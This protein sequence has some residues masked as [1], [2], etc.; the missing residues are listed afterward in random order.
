MG[1][2]DEQVRQKKQHDEEVFGDA[3]IKMARAA[4]GGKIKAALNGGGERSKD[5]MGEILKF[6]HVKNRE[7][8]DNIKDND[9][10]L[11]Y[12]MRP[13]GI[14]RR[15]VRLL[16]GWHKDA[17][18]AMLGMKKDGGMVA[19]IPAGFFGYR[20]YDADSGAYVRIGKKNEGLFE[21]EAIAFYKPLPMKK[22]GLRDL[23]RY[24]IDTL[25][26]ADILFAALTAFAAALFGLAAPRLSSL[27]FSDVIGSG[28]AR[29]LAAA[30]IFMACAGIG[31][32]LMAGAKTL[33]HARIGTKTGFAVESAVMMRILSLPVDFFKRYSS[34]ELSCRARHISSLSR[35]LVS[36]LLSVGLAA[37]F[38]LI[39]VIQIFT[40]APVLAAPAIAV[41]AAEL[42]ILAISAWI[43]RKVSGRRMKLEAR[44]GGM[45]YAMISGIQKIKLSGAEK[46]AFARWGDLY[47]QCVRLAYHPPFFLK[48]NSVMTLAVSL[49]GTFAIYDAA[50]SLRVPATDYYA[51]HVAYG[52]VSAAFF[53]LS[54][55]ALEAAKTGPALEM[56]RP[57]LETEPE[58]A[59]EKQVVSRISGGIELNNV[60]FRYGEHM[61]PVLDDLTLKI[62]PGQYVAIVGAT[63]CGKSTL[64][65]LML[66]FEK[67]Q[68]GAVFYDGRD[69]STLD[70]K[71]LRQKIGVVLQ[72]GKLFS[73]D[74]YSNITLLAPQLGMEGAW[75]AAELA[76]AA[77]DIKDMPMGMFTM[78]SEGS[79]GISGGQR[80]RILIA[81]AIAH[82]PRILMFDEATSALD[83]LTQK[84]V[85]N[86]LDGMKCTRIVI[87]HRLSTIRQCDRI[88][89]LD[90]GKI[91]EDGTYEELVLRDGFFAGLVARQQVDGKRAVSQRGGCAS[92]AVFRG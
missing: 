4:S 21:S 15:T 45:G 40:Y 89:V 86:A 57:I 29:A 20:Y 14:M 67:P 32:R 73:G 39:Y 54:A 70:L 74:I 42:F 79:G 56:A 66:G 82:K 17:A 37:V 52:M 5:A 22:L 38:S 80:Q 48:M 46:P 50:V 18:G 69:I 51:F 30:A 55:V 71:S 34:G 77:Q 3:F 44:E 41:L 13:Y 90:K 11:E 23:F 91:I 9:G 92:G 53:E 25:S 24:I 28:N 78:V 7:L 58:I 33:I 64:M 35:M 2:F 61:P 81:R 65:R 43:Q 83:N 8:P 27:I 36:E 47:A 84:Q 76:G 63:G 85:S 16:D 59:E 62:Y 26:I 19:L 6:Y 1:W 12:L 31:S 49:A 68:K 87:A 72:D 60:S 75:E 88:V 10:R